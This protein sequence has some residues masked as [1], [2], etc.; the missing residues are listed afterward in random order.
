VC[1]KADVGVG[2]NKPYSTVRARDT[3]CGYWLMRQL[4]CKTESA[5]RRRWGSL[6]TR[7][8]TRRL[9]VVPQ[10]SFCDP[11]AMVLTATS[12]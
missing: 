9:E 3:R 2:D 5:A 1:N 7:R 12:R 10:L 8:L 11:A 4:R 6:R